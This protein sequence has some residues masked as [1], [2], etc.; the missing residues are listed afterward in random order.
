MRPNSNR[1]SAS[2]G[3]AAKQSDLPTVN[4]ILENY[5]K[6][7]GG[8]E[9]LTAVKTIS[10]RG[11]LSI[12]AAGVKGNVV[13]Q[14]SASGKFLMNVDIPGLENLSLARTARRFGNPPA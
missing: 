12:P 8:K 13:M 4:Q 7:V 9:K 5:V 1:N 2:Q 14:Q 10:S 11:T 3:A 6:A